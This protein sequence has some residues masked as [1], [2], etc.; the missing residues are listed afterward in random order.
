MRPVEASKLWHH[1]SNA[2]GYI[3]D[4]WRPQSRKLLFADSGSGAHDDGDI[5]TASQYCV[6]QEQ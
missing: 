3:A 2:V 6:G 1:S 4:E 5:S